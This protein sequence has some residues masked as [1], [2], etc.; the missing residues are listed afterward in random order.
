MMSDFKFTVDEITLFER[1]VNF[2]MPFRYGI[3]TLTSAP[4]AYIRVRITLPSGKSFIGMSAD[5]LA[6]KWFD[7]N[8]N[9]T[10]EDNFDQLR[11]SVFMAARLYRD[12]RKPDTAFG[13]HHSHEGLHHGNCAS[14][15][16]P[17][18]VAS[19][20]I[21]LIDRAILDA[22]C[23]A[24]KTSLF[25]AIRLNLPGL[26]AGTAG[27]LRDF[28]IPKFL[29]SLRPS[30]KIAIRHTVGLTDAIE[31]SDIA[32]EDRI[33]D[34]LPQSLAANCA[35]YGVKSF[36]IKLSG[37]VE[38]DYERLEKISSVLNSLNY[39]YFCT[40]DGNEQFKDAEQFG[41]FWQKV[42]SNPKLVT[43]ANRVE[44]IEQPIN[45]KNALTLPLG[46]MGNELPCEIDES[47]ANIDAFPEAVKMGYRGISSKSCKGIYR[48]L[49]NR[50]RVEMLNNNNKG[51]PFFMSAED[52]STQAGTALQQDLSLATLIGCKHIE[53]NG[54]QYGDGLSGMSAE[55]RNK[56]KE[57][58][59]D[60]YEIQDNRLCLN[61]VA[62]AISLSSLDVLA[63]G[64]KTFPHE[65]DSVDLQSNFRKLNEYG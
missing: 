47:D 8:P 17:G 55:W 37:D 41:S 44:I 2:R 6:P 23:R 56:L 53:R 22:C 12:V 26:H 25:N 43:L 30:N 15:A 65:G 9:L 34:H 10:N 33:N 36:K 7:K 14:E 50:T 54:H 46:E 51:V 49:L 39:D 35:H 45:R 57:D 52:L 11:K 20:G 59:E 62:G 31:D 48:S 63:Y 4:E 13:H 18:L 5:L 42:S 21:A 19:F 29:E 1:P 3:V 58:H 28:D 24:Q 60:L 64:T 16:L 27:D 32:D 38:T 61:I 40:V